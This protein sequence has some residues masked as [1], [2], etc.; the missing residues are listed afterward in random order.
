MN[1]ASLYDALAEKYLE[2][3]IRLEMRAEWQRLRSNDGDD[4]FTADAVADFPP[5]NVLCKTQTTWY[6]RAWPFQGKVQMYGDV[7]IV[8]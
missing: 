2:D 5:P 3:R 8:Y 1:T 7:I 6:E 4:I